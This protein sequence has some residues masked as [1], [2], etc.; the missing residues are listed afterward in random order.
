MLPKVSRRN[1]V[2]I[3][4]ELNEAENKKKIKRIMKLTA[5]SLK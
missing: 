3:T 4:A 1:D 2:K 5:D